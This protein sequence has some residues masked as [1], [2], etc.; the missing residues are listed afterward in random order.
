[1]VSDITLSGQISIQTWQYLFCLSQVL[2]TTADPN[3]GGFSFDRL[4]AEYFAED[5]KKRFKVDAHAQPRAYVRLLQECERLKKLMSANSQE[6]PLNIECF[7]DEKDVSGKMGRDTLEKLAEELLQRIE[8][9]MRAVLDYASEFC[10]ICFPR[11]SNLLGLDMSPAT[12]LII[13]QYFGKVNKNVNY[14]PCVICC[15]MT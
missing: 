2:A 7:I 12:A 8:D 9:L 10:L 3:L 13:L 4:L 14:L 11:D 5:F 1:M 15:C 6:I